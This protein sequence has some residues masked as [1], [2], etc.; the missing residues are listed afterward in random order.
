MNTPRPYDAIVALGVGCAG[1]AMHAALAH[2]GPFAAHDA[3]VRPRP[4]MSG[5][6]E[7]SRA[8]RLTPGGLR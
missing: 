1:I 5:G 6:R 7:A 4:R 8:S 2:A 3:V